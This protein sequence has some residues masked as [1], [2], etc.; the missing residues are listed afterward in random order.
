MGAL[1]LPV[2]RHHRPDEEWWEAERTHG[3]GYCER[4]GLGGHAGAR[5]PTIQPFLLRIER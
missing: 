4:C 5:C 2:E 1:E 3:A